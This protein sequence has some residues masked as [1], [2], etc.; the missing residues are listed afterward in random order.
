LQKLA[1]HSADACRVT[2]K[3]PHNFLR[4]GLIDLVF[5]YK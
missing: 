3:M 2:D 4:L 5:I 1:G